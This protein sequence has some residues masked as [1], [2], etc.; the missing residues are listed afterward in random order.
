MS[1]RSTSP[2]PLV[3]ADARPDEQ[4]GTHPLNPRS[5][6]RYVSLGTCA[7]MERVGV[8]LIRVPPGRESRVRSS[9]FR[10]PAT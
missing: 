4:L 10:H 9:V 5:E 8:H 3:R 2:H 1:D 6:M 7:G